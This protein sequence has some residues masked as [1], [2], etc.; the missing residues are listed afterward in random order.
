MYFQVHQPFRLRKYGVLDIGRSADYFDEAA[1]RRIMEKVASKCYLPANA[2]LL[3]LIRRHRGR[4]KVAFSISATALQQFARYA[5][6]VLTSF[7]RLA[8]TGCV[9]FL[10]ETAYHSL[11]FLYD[12]AEFDRQVDLH[13]DLIEAHFRQFP[14]VFRNTELI[15]NNSL[16]AHL[17]KRGFAAV[18]A[19][20]AD[21]VLGWRSPNFLH[22]ARG[23]PGIKVL[24]KN[25]R[26]SDD[27]AFRFSD[28]NWSQYPL[29]AGRYASWIHA[30]NGS[31]EV[32]NLFMDYETF[33]EH[34]W[35]ESG[36]F[37]FLDH[38]PAAILEHPDNCFATPHEIAS[39]FAS[40]GELDVPHFVSWAD[41]ER[42]LSAWLGNPMQ[43]AAAKALYG[44]GPA[45]QASGDE[46]L[47]ESWRRLTTSDHLYYMCTKFFA[48]GD[49]HK[50]FN[51]YDSPYE[52][53]IAFMNTVNDLALRAGARVAP[54]A[55]SRVIADEAPARRIVVPVTRTTQRAEPARRRSRVAPLN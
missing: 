16:A 19:E 21:R 35:A 24:L 37:A 31:G 18:L 20:G 23:A 36:I 15:F 44:L 30:I 29:D 14:T 28:R 26:L 10:A 42:D 46:K 13:M 51:P 11:S 52:A 8:D 47:L 53:Y 9:E 4:F 5:P 40:A 1:N 6:G 41:T 45:V 17:E 32:V 39:R 25:Y 50:Y 48:D 33:G 54:P 22:T 43:E 12:R 27:I 3:D 49:V 7:R 38:L 34:Q 55:T 2:L